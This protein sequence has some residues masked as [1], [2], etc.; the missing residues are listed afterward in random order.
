MELKQMI[1]SYIYCEKTQKI[2][3]M[4]VIFKDGNTYEFME[5]INNIEYNKYSPTYQ[6]HF[7]LKNIIDK[8]L[9]LYPEKVIDQYNNTDVYLINTD[10]QELNFLLSNYTIKNI[11]INKHQMFKFNIMLSDFLKIFKTY[12]IKIEYDNCLNFNNYY[13]LIN[14]IIINKIHPI[15]LTFLDNDTK[16][17]LFISMC[18]KTKFM[19]PKNI[20]ICYKWFEW[21]FNDKN[22]DEYS[23]DTM[24]IIMKYMY[25]HYIKYYVHKN[26]FEYDNNCFILLYCK[27]KKFNLPLNNIFINNPLYSFDQINIGTSTDIDTNIN[28]S[29]DISTDTSIDIDIYK[30]NELVKVCEINLR[31]QITKQYFGVPVIYMRRQ[32]ILDDYYGNIT[33]EHYTYATQYIYS[34][35]KFILNNYISNMTNDYLNIFIEKRSE[36]FKLSTILLFNEI[37]L[38]RHI[39][40]CNNKLINID[41]MLEDLKSYNHL[42]ST[43][44]EFN[45]TITFNESYTSKYILWYMVLNNCYIAF[46]NIIDGYDLDILNILIIFKRIN[47]GGIIY[48]PFIHQIIINTLMN[49]HGECNLF[50]IVL[51][52]LNKIIS[53]NP[54][55]LTKYITDIHTK[56]LYIKN[57]TTHK[58]P[59][60]ICDE[61]ES[62]IEILSK[63]KFIY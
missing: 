14:Y 1:E 8:Y 55:I 41:I 29:T 53:K 60:I 62:E 45:I 19:N 23:K 4:P 9:E 42:C 2:F 43:L 15:W 32:N 44:I 56:M 36:Q 20:N 33:T 24:I 47:I 48:Q 34:F 18:D 58:P 46:L 10:M 51:E 37:E 30:F 13:D 17:Q 40:F 7:N 22:D 50:N 52:Y 12:N 38:K 57:R 59:N 11:K 54:N 5:I 6:I 31:C 28:T 35:N 25:S 26:I 3:K 21:A 16:Q 27:K 63:V 39:G 61:D 49:I